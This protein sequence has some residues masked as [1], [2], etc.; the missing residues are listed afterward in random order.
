MPRS[1]REGTVAT[2]KFFQLVA[3]I[4]FHYVSTPTGLNHQNGPLAISTA[5]QP[6]RAVPAIETKVKNRY[7]ERSW[8]S[9][10]TGLFAAT[11]PKKSA[12]RPMSV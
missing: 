7:D 8:E 12:C 9:F 1:E 6:H 3:A 2:V 10:D 11:S 4:C 5:S